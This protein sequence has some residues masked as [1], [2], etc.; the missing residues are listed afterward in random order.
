MNAIERYHKRVAK[1]LAA[2]MDA[3]FSEEDHPRDEN[4]RFSSGGGGGGKQKIDFEK[5]TRD[6]MKEWQEQTG[7]KGTFP[8]EAVEK[9]MKAQS[10]AGKSK[11]GKQAY[12]KGRAIGHGV[13]LTKEQT[14]QADK[15]YREQQKQE[16]QKARQ[17]AENLDYKT[18]TSRT[19]EKL[20]FNNE[21]VK[22]LKEEAKEAIRQRGEESLRRS[23]YDPKKFDDDEIFLRGYPRT[24]DAKDEL[25]S[26]L[27]T[28]KKKSEE[29]LNTM[30]KKDLADRI[31]FLKERQSRLELIDHWGR[32]TQDYWDKLSREKQRV[33]DVYRKRFG[34]P[35]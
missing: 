13:K 24:E 30:P 15:R 25:L 5:G 14:E 34:N 17:G 22:K 16:A 7:M 20:D 23:G 21:E 6:R 18:I 33:T 3:G 27:P 31:N 9:G 2:R 28:F 11:S 35:E 8:K 4:G 32:E 26:S 19:G 12:Q 10:G 1:R 29:R